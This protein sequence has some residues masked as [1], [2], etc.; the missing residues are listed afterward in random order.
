MNLYEPLKNFRFLAIFSKIATLLGNAKVLAILAILIITVAAYIRIYDLGERSLW[1]DEAWLANAVS[2]DSL[3][4]VMA[5]LEST[6][7]LFAIVAHYIISWL[8]NNEFTLRLLP[9]GFGIGSIILI[10]F[11]TR[12]LSNA[13]AALLALIPFAFAPKLVYYAKEFKQYSGD[14]FF[15]VLLV[16]LTEIIIHRHSFKNWILFVVFASVGLWFSH[17]MTFVVPGLALVLL[18]YS[19]ATGKD[20]GV[21]KQW[22]TAHLVIGVL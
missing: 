22:F 8:R 17:P 14:M 7:P 21:L 9:C 5:S 18:Y 20:R 16:F 15:A 19:L 10:F 3:K 2:E 13:K 4:G 1:L 6:P 12:K 11:L